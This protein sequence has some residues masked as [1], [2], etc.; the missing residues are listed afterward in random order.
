MTAYRVMLADD[1]ALF[2]SGV[3]RIL[4]EIPEVE[5]VGEAADGMQLLALLKEATPDLVILDI[6]MP[7]MDGFALLD[8]K[9]ADA[10]LRDVPVMI[11]SAMDLRENSLESRLFVAS[12][13]NGLT[14]AKLLECAVGISE[15]LFKPEMILDRA[16][17]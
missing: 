15:I 9:K 13:A 2:R 6:S 5:V 8:R 12:M 4:E 3:K 7:E 14:A 1:H 17:G 11:V 16:S 10:A